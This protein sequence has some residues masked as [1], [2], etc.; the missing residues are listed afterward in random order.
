MQIALSIACVLAVAF[1]FSNSLKTGEESSEQSSTVVD[2]IQDVAA[3]FDPDSPIAT[4]TGED[5]QRLHSDVRTL[6]HFGE[7]ALLGALFSACC[8]SYT[9]KA[10]F[11]GIPLFGALAVPCMDEGLQAF[12][13]DRAA[14]WKDILVDVTGGACGM[15][16]AIACVLVGLW[17]YKKIQAKK[18]GNPPKEC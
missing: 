17:L 1:I 7:F 12:V 18:R 6:A 4:A 14:D 5:Y 15:A 3:F 9:L 13:A 2:I 16:F 10:P 11:Q 8:F